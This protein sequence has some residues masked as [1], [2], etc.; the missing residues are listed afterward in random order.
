MPLSLVSC[1]HLPTV[2]WLPESA[3]AYRDAWAVFRLPLADCPALMP[4][5]A[6]WLTTDEQTRA[7]RYRQSADRLRFVGGRMALRVVAGRYVG[8]PPAA[9]PLTIG[10]YG[11]PE[12]DGATGW[13]ANVSH[14]GEWILLAV[15]RSPVGIDT[16]GINPQFS[17]ADLLPA[18]FG[19]AEQD[20]LARQPDPRQAFYTLWTRKE[21]LVKATGIGMTDDLPRLPVL[22]GTQSVESG[23][24][25]ATGTWVVQSFAVSDTYPAAVAYRWEAGSAAGAV[26]F[27]ALDAPSLL[28]AAPI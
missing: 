6:T 15:G 18:G 27:Y 20:W 1:A 24:L 19:V 25:G 26:P 21:A 7:E 13:H 12:L 17:Y 9:L 22:D 8:Q 3:C 4:H 2:T 23:L 11:K 16:E 10:P 28:R 5:V 14:T